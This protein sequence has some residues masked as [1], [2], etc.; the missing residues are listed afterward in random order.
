MP[1]SLVVLLV[2]RTNLFYFQK[3]RNSPGFAEFDDMSMFLTNIFDL[4]HIMQ[5]GFWRRYI[6]VKLIKHKTVKSFNNLQQKN[7]MILFQT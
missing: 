5:N 2:F 7:R 3:F 4:K 6:Y 1:N